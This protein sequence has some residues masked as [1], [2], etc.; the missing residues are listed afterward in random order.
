MARPKLEACMFC[1]AVPCECEPKKEKPKRAPRKKAKQEPNQEVKSEA[2]EEQKEEP[3][4]DKP[5]WSSPERGRGKGRSAA[6]K[7]LKS[8]SSKVPA[9]Q[10]KVSPQNG[11]GVAASKLMERDIGL[12]RAER[13]FVELGLARPGSASVFNLPSPAGKLLEGRDNTHGTDPKGAR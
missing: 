4:A 1:D 7:L 2:K 10:G 5:A 11:R 12:F 9:G 3:A 13:T 6:S 8:E